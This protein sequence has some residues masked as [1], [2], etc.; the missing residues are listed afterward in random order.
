MSKLETI[1]FTGQTRATVQRAATS[2]TDH[3]A[4][5]VRMTSPSHHGQDVALDAVA[6]HPAAEQLFAGAWSACYITA[7]TLVAQQMKVALPGDL[8][9][10]IA[11][12]LG[13]AGPEWVLQARFDVHAPGLDQ[14][15]AEKIVHAA[16]AICPYSK[17]V[18]GNI[19]VAVNVSV[20]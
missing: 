19:D 12:D 10:R 16:H 14:A 4:V 5:D 2:A 17:A 13:Q 6:P 7:V 8:E 11:I 18:K 15:V 1:L 9:V 3:G 20:A